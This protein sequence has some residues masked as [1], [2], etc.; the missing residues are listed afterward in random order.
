M[1]VKLSDQ[2]VTKLLAEWRAGDEGAREQ[3]LSIVYDQLRSLAARIM[4][5][6]RPDHTLAAT[7]LVHEAYLRLAGADVPWQDRAHFFRLA[8][9]TMR[10]ILVDYA[11]AHRRTKRGGGAGK[12]SLEELG[13]IPGADS[14]LPEV[15]EAL[16]RLAAMDPR[17][18]EVIDLIY[19][20]GL[21]CNEAAEALEISPTT[22]QREV[23]IAKSFLYHELQG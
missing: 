16:E 1:M 17:K 22:V 14:C 13:D 12:I 18:A 3:L 15:D 9:R 5:G 21:T 11:K 6:E 19:F 2:P 8:A 23:R 4:T 7:G 20:G 10:R